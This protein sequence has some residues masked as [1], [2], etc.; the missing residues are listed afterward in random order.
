LGVAAGTSLA[1][2]GATIGSNALAVTGSSSFPGSTSISSTGLVGIGMTPSNILD[3]T[4]STN[5]ASRFSMLNNNAGTSAYVTMKQDN[6]TSTSQH[7]HYGASYTTSGMLRQNGTLLYTDGAGGITISTGAGGPPIYFGINLTEVARF[8]TSGNLAFA[9]GS[10]GIIFNNSSATVNSTLNDYEV[11]TFTPTFTSTTI[12]GSY[13]ATGYYTK[14]GAMVF[15]SVTVVGATTFT[16][17][18]NSSSM[19]GLPFT[20]AGS[21]TGLVATNNYIEDFGVGALYGGTTAYLPS[22]NQTGTAKSYFFSG[23]YRA[24]F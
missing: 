15:I 23:T 4:Q 21:T 11:G 2:G 1:L 16:S 9:S 17:T 18:A 3:I 12:G 20:L 19:N 13:A 8:D 24:S 7:I 6:G 14:V 5:G 10:R 22:I